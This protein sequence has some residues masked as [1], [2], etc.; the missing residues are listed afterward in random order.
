MKNL[1]KNGKD[2]RQNAINLPVHA[3]IQL[4]LSFFNS[5]EMKLFMFLF[6][7][8]LCTS[9]ARCQFSKSTQ[10]TTYTNVL[11]QKSSR[12]ETIQQTPYGQ[13]VQQTT[14]TKEQG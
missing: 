14:V 7:L 8:V 4:Q 9:L 13:T 12:T 3:T 2:T 1:P 5:L 11:G 10:T 6:I